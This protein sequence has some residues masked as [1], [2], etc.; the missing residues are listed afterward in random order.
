MTKLH[1]IEIASDM[2]LA[3]IA[4]NPGCCY[5]DLYDFF[6]ILNPDAICYIVLNLVDDGIL[7]AIKERPDVQPYR[8]RIVGHDSC[9]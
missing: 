7:E 4:R 9:K 6:S 8:F 3:Y 5:D 1:T 2:I